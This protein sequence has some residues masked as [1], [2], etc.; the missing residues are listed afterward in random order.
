MQL[1]IEAL[2]SLFTVECM[3]LMI[4]GTAVGI[5]F[6]AMPGMSA[7][8]A[9]AVFIPLTYSMDV[10]TAVSMLMALYIGGI[11]GGLISAILINIPGTP[12]SVATTF[13]GAPMARKGLGGKALGTGVVFSFIGTVLSL[14][15]LIF[16]APPLAKIAFNFGF[17]EYFA[18]TSC[19]FVLVAGLAGDNMIKGLISAAFG[20]VFSIVGMAPLDGVHRFTFGNTNMA[21]GLAQLPVLVGLFAL[22]E[23]LKYVRTEDLGFAKL[24]VPKIKGFGFSVKEFFGEFGNMIRSALIGIGVGIIPGIGGATSNLL[25]YAAAKNTSK[26]RET[27]GTGVMGGVVASETANNASIGGAMIP[28]LSLG[29]PG[30]AVTA[31]LLGALM[32]KGLQ[33]GPMFFRTSIDIAYAIFAAMFVAAVLMLLLEF[34][35]LR[36]FMKMLSI[37]RQILLPVVM[38]ICMVGAYTATNTIFSMGVLFA[39]G[40]IGYVLGEFKVPLAPAIIGF[41]LGSPCELYLR[42]GLQ[43]TGGRFLPFL[44]SPISAC[45]YAV[46]GLFILWKIFS[47]VRRQIKPAKSV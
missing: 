9:V 43:L 45:I 37:P 32:V 21:A 44:Q 16:I 30:D 28:L 22:P 39:F 13:D 11:S 33:P 26:N 3:G 6:G 10:I 14:S 40:L 23:L 18:I 46:A 17:Y 20:V 24:A 25:A 42:R 41:V 4:V 19:A 5:L 2:S 7:T 29:I 35:G 36:V 12:A 27:Y 1:F 31:I 15:A 38:V 47:A 34:Y 8:L